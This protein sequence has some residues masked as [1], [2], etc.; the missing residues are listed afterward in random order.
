MIDSEHQRDRWKREVA[1]R[2]CEG[3]RKSI[4]TVSCSVR[5]LVMPYT[6][7]KFE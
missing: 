6:V 4:F 2:G 3:L 5:V 7:S 1:C